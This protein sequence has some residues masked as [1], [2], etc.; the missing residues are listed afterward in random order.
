M[1]KFTRASSVA[2]V[3][4]ADLFL[5]EDQKTLVEANNPRASHLL[6]RAGQEIPQRVAERFGLTEGTTVDETSTT[7]KTS[8]ATVAPEDIEARSKRPSVPSAKR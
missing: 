8:T 4:S 7:D 6:A 5:A 1:I 2:L 3:A